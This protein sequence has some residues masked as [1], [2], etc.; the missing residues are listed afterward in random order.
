MPISSAA[1]LFTCNE[2]VHKS[3][4]AMPCISQEVMF[5]CII[6]GLAEMIFACIIFVNDSAVIILES[7]EGAIEKNAPLH[8]LDHLARSWIC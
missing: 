7:T 2:E 4:V 6:T 3:P 1:M 8:S 5:N